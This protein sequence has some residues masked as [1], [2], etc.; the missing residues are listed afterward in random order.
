MAAATAKVSMLTNTNDRKPIIRALYGLD[1]AG[2]S[3]AAALCVTR[4][5][6]VEEAAIAW[7][8]R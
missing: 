6:P 1:G 4:L 7:A 2:R 3:G 5:R 8:L